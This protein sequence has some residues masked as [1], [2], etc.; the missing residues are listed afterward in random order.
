LKNEK[1]AALPQRSGQHGSGDC[2]YY[3]RWYASP[4]KMFEDTQRTGY[5]R[6]PDDAVSVTLQ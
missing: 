6:I 4:E 1:G 3:E 5:L 2:N